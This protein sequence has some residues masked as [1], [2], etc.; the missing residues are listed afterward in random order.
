MGPTGVGSDVKSLIGSRI[1]EKDVLHQKSEE[2]I[3]NAALKTHMCQF[4]S[5]WMTHVTGKGTYEGCL[6]TLQ[7]FAEMYNAKRLLVICGLI[8]DVLSTFG[9]ESAEE[10]SDEGES[11]YQGGLGW[12]LV[13]FNVGKHPLRGVMAEATTR[14]FYSRP[15]LEGAFEGPDGREC[16]LVLFSLPAVRLVLFVCRSGFD[17]DRFVLK[18]TGFKDGLLEVR[19]DVWALML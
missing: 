19:E 11:H 13:G 17:M 18:Y 14:S 8:V 7:L 10:D 6:S 15:G 5:A 12:S 3:K 1:S 9:E 2:M 4:M 16:T